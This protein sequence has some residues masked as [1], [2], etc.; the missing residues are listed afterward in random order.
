[1]ASISLPTAVAISAGAGLVGSGISAMAASGA[2]NTESA[3][4]QTAAQDQM[5]MFNTVN[6]QL[7]PFRT[8]GQ[9][10]IPMAEGLLGI[11]PTAGAGA[12][13]APGV[14]IGATGGKLSGMLKQY[15]LSNTPFGQSVSQALA[16]GNWAGVQAATNRWA[17]T[18]TNPAN[19]GMKSAITGLVSNPVMQTAAAPSAGAAGAPSNSMM[20]F[21]AQTPGYQFTR[22]QGLESVQSGFAAQ[23][24]ADSGAA[25]KGAANY[26]T[27]LAEN[28]YQSQ[29]NNYL[30]L[31]NTGL[32]AATAGGQLGVQ[33]QST[34][35]QYL[36]SGA[37]AAAAG[38]IGVA[39]ALSGGLN[40]AASLGLLY[41]LNPGG[42]FG[43]PAATSAASS[44]NPGSLNNSLTGFS[45]T[46]W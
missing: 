41:G 40:N 3:A 17:A 19:A 23:G 30:N 27:G 5:D 25:L 9:A 6:N 28:T 21:L 29:L 45:G 32:T 1:M 22:Q 46:T 18:T 36:T 12:A 2:A 34:A 16:S 43:A 26:A 38:Q 15:G 11:G 24:L 7:A 13:A 44:F 42:M 31:M 10:A 20:D 14:D 4:A 33:S 8:A 35:N 39:N 37:S